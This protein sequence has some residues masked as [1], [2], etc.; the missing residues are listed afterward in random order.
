M[1]DIA[2]QNAAAYAAKYRLRLVEQLGFGIHGTVH[3]AEDR[4]KKDQSAVKAHLSI[5]PYL[6][7]RDIYQRLKEAGISEVLDFHVPQLIR[8]DDSLQVIEMT[9]VTRPFVL[10]FAG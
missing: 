7:E 10:D 5:E 6:R 3:V 1:N 4:V 8:A 9:I 2:V